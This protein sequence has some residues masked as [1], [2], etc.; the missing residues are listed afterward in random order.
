MPLRHAVT[1]VTH[2]MNHKLLNWTPMIE[3]MA[4][5]PLQNHKAS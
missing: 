3:Y 4:H 5:E 1:Q 2:S